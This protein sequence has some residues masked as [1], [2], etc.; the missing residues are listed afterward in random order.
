[1]SSSLDGWFKLTST[2]PLA[3]GWLKASSVCAP[4]GSLSSSL[5]SLTQASGSPSLV[6]GWIASAERSEKLSNR[7]RTCTTLRSAVGENID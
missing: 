2:L 1:M 5:V 3:S 7:A 6:L 4:L